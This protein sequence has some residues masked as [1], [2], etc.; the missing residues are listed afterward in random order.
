MIA[1]ARY[2]QNLPCPETGVT[3]TRRESAKLRLE[4]M[5]L[6]FVRY[7]SASGELRSVYVY[8]GEFLLYVADYY[9]TVDYLQIHQE[10]NVGETVKRYYAFLAH[11]LLLWGPK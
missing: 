9:P 1:P 2:I 6:R 8:C 11:S 3:L 5:G 7:N 4:K 10:G